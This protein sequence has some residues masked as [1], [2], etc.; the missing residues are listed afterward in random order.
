[1]S[2]GL[3]ERLLNPLRQ[4]IRMQL[5]ATLLGLVLVGSLML[6]LVFYVQARRTALDQMRKSYDGLARTAASLSAYDMQFN[7]AGLKNT[8]RDM[9][10]ADANLFWLEFVDA[11]GKVLETGGHLK[12]APYGVLP[13]RTA[14]N[15]ISTLSTAEGSALLV[16]SPIVASAA[17]SAAGLG[18]IGFEQPAAPQQAQELGELRLVV[19]LKPLSDLRRGYVFF[20]AILI[21]IMLAIGGVASIGIT[22]Y[23]VT[24][25]T[26]LSKYAE[27]VASGHLAAYEG[28][29]QR[30]D[31][32]GRLVSS[33]Q[34]MAVGLGKIVQE[35]RDAFQRVEEGTQAV[36]KNLAS[37][38]E[39]TKEQETSSQQVQQRITAIE[40]SVAEV[41]RLMEG[42][43]QL[44]E[45][46]SSSVLQMIA[47]I[48]QIASNTEGLTESMN[49]AASTLSQNV[50]AIR[51]ID[52]S[53]EN[54]NRFVEEISAAMSEMEASIRQI[55][56]NAGKTRKAT[57]QVAGEAE[58]GARSVAESSQA[59]QKL[60]SSFEETVK[61]MNLLGRRSEEVGQILAVIDEVMEQT[62]LLALN[63]AIIAAQAGE[64]GKSFAVVADE[65]KEL[66]G[67]TSVS[68][69]EIA[70]LIDAV[71]RDVK[72]AVQSVSAQ[73]G[74]VEQSVAVS[75]QTRKAFERIQG[76]VDP[77]LRMVQEIARATAEQAK[78]ASSIVRST[79]QLRDL[80]HQLRRG[81]KEQS[82]GSQ[83]I[84]DAVNRIRTLSEDMKRATGE[85]AAGSAIIRQAMDR[86]TAAVA[87][88]LAL[89]LAQKKA[90]EEVEEVMVAFSRSNQANLQSTQEASRQVEA[91]AQRSE[92]VARGMSRFHIEGG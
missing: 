53:A 3:A 59:V 58:A 16:R 29:I 44:A 83:Q 12:S 20:G 45:E 22:R 62:H 67:K 37:T 90:S 50:A 14:A 81:T 80:A 79:E 26:S 43:S 57:E 64:H 40:K 56:E 87:E 74:L 92:E 17:P 38:L 19:S 51:E 27:K 71:Q 73:S 65:I 69:R 7:K 63:A 11:Q 54:L 1:M 36:R 68:T 31:E 78:G 24:P 85:Q 48:D 39:N 84:L 55:E 28:T 61:V 9:A 42:L 89:N 35:I 82:L 70:A 77:S 10:A 33:F 34:S 15:A 76:A 18:D 72:Q 88:V 91:L 46:V 86:L 23:F 66:A 60:Q 4:S 13:Q 21:L 52:A 49:T 75:Q 5:L 47:S 6:A 2:E 32:L 8:V 30:K 41:A 25:L